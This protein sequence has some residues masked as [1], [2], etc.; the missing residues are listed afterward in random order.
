MAWM[1][2]FRASSNVSKTGPSSWL[3]DTEE[4]TLTGPNDWP[5]ASHEGLL[6]FIT[7]PHHARGLLKDLVG[8]SILLHPT[9]D[10]DARYLTAELAGDYAGLLRLAAGPR[11]NWWR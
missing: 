9:D 2:Q 3:T 10:K 7:F 11:L 5:I 8:G 6:A 4:A 1:H